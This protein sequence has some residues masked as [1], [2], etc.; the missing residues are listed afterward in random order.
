MRCLHCGKKVP[1]LRRFSNEEF[2][3]DAHRSAFQQQQQQI[4]LSRLQEA[5]RR[6]EPPPQAVVRKSSPGRVP[7]PPEAGPLVEKTGLVGRRRLHVLA[8]APY[9]TMGAPVA[10]VSPVV[11]PRNRSHGL[12]NPMNWAPAGVPVLVTPEAVPTLA[13]MAPA[14]DPA[15]PVFSGVHQGREMTEPA[16]PPAAALLPLAGGRVLAGVCRHALIRA[17]RLEV[18]HGGGWRSGLDLAPEP[19][20]MAPPVR[21]VELEVAR[22]EEAP[23]LVKRLY[24]VFSPEPSG[25]SI[26]PAS[27]H[28]EPGWA[29]SELEPE[30]PPARLDFPSP[31]FG[32]GGVTPIAAVMALGGLPLPSF[33]AAVR[34]TESRLMPGLPDRQADYRLPEGAVCDVAGPLPVAGLFELRT[35]AAGA[36]TGN[37]ES[38][39]EFPLSGWNPPEPA[40]ADAGASGIPVAVLGLPS[41]LTAPAAVAVVAPVPDPLAPLHMA[42]VEQVTGPV[43]STAA[44]LGAEEPAVADGLLPAPVL[45]S[46]EGAAEHV[47]REE[48]IPP[49][50]TRALPIHSPRAMSGTR[51]MARGSG[52]AAKSFW[53]EPMEAMPALRGSGLRLDHADGSGP[54]PVE[55]VRRKRLNFQWLRMP[56]LPRWGGAWRH[57]PADLKWVSLAIPAVLVLVIYSLIPD[58]PMNP[59]AGQAGAVEQAEAPT[60]LGDRF[61]TLQ[62]VIME[63]AAIRLVDDFRSGLGAWSGGPGWAKT[64]QYNAANF[65]T[66]GRLALYGPTSGMRDYEVAFLAQIDRRSLNWVVRAADE[67]NYHVIRILITQPGPLPK[68]VVQRYAVIGGRQG[69]VTTLPL[70]IPVRTDTLYKVRMEVKGDRFIT[71]VQDQVV[72]S[73]TDSRLAAGGVGFFSP[74]GDR[75][76]LR[77]V[78]VTHQ[79][80]YLGR[81]CALLAPHSVQAEGRRVE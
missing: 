77:W 81:I 30:R 36:M 56:R 62:K 42:R 60:V 40:L 69:A 14:P 48:G 66:P 72:D 24:R 43:V 63:R 18:A 9:W 79:Y 57:A 16:E 31:G 33:R 67:Q 12:E 68:A 10:P 74:P 46:V 28:R 64:W 22:A 17:E 59:A 37:P 27:S 73:F 75:A 58:Q 25:S 52:K 29:H 2:C 50:L 45:A 6:L 71:Y 38:D 53:H 49:A 65:V 34:W 11:L 61:S 15:L 8:L 78:S 35:G 54:R 3:S 41:A 19:A 13:A 23:P 44:V 21:Q 70:P 5:G 26:R 80:D 20:R 76:L 47:E 4:A 7:D 32:F 51:V 1:F 39:P 55:V